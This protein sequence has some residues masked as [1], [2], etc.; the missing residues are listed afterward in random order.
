MV[1]LSQLSTAFATTAVGGN[2]E[3][4]AAAMAS[5]KNAVE[6]NLLSK[7]KD[8]YLFEKSKEFNEK[9]YLMERDKEHTKAYLLEYA[10][11]DSLIKP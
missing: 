3:T 8:E 1:A 4:A 11:I 2:G 6:N 10:Y 7:E 9:G 5:A